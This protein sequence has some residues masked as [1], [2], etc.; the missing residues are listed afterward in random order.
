MLYVEVWMLVVSIVSINLALIIY[1]IAIWSERKRKTLLFWHAIMF[2]IGFV[3]DASGT[4]M[5][6]K[7]G[8]SKIRFGFHDILGYIALLLMFLNAIGAIFILCKKNKE[9]TKEFYKF[10]VFSWV[11][12]AISYVVGMAVNM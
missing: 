4:F 1:T 10:G 6:Y 7:L 9:S 11:V 12:W 8:G 2:S 5:M 3:F